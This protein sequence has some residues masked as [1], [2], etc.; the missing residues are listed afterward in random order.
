MNILSFGSRFPNEQSCRNYLK[1]KREQEG[2]TCKHCGSKKHYWLGSKEFWKCADCGSKTNLRAGTIMV[3][4]KIPVR[5]WFMCVHL[6]TSTKKSISALE[7]QRQLGMKRY[8]PVWYMMQKIRR[9]MGKRDSRYKLKGHVEVDDSFFEIVDLEIP[10]EE[11]ELKRG[12]GSYRQKKVLV[13]V[14]ST[15]NP[16]QQNPHK[17]KRIMGFVKMVTI[18]ELTSVGINYELAK[19]VEKTS[20]VYTDAYHSFSSVNKVVAKHIKEVTPS[21]EAHEKLPWVHA[22]ISNAKRQFLGVHHSIGKDYLQNYLNEF[23]Y[24]LNRRTFETDLFDRMI[25]AGASDTWF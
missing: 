2:I 12:R 13:M 9:S 25:V 11:T 16:K 6:M 15:P 4:S 20:T 24:K 18:D 23:C 19:A 3:K 8:E 21:K 7:M 1:K 10:V 5:T 22:T 17:K 14:E